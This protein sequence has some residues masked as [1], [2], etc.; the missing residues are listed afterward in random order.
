MNY[1][2]GMF[3][4]SFDPL[5][6][7]HIHDIIRAASMCETL[8]VMISWCEGRESTSKE[9]RYRWILD[10]CRHLPNVK[11]LLIEDTAV[12]KAS[13]NTD[14]YWEKGAAD[15]KN[16]IGKPID[17][18]FCGTDYFGTNRF[19]SL[20]EPES[21]V[22]YFD[23]NE[24]PICSTNIR[25]WAFDNWSYIPKICRPYY[26]K[27]VLVVGGEST[28][29]STLVINLAL[30]YNT[31]Y[32]DEVGRDISDMA[33]SEDL[34]IMDDFN[35]IL[36]RHKVNELNAIK[37]SNKLLFI[38]TDSITTQF[39]ANLLL[40]SDEENKICNQLADAI[41]NINNYDLV[42]FLEPTV[43]FI[44]DGTRNEI[45]ASDRKKYS[46]QIKSL[47][48]KNNIKY[49]CLSG[50]YLSRFNESK[51]LIERYL[52]FPVKQEDNHD[53]LIDKQEEIKTNGT[54][55]ETYDF[56]WAF[57]T[58]EMRQQIAAYVREHARNSWDKQNVNL[59]YGV[60]EKKNSLI[61]TQVNYLSDLIMRTDTGFNYHEF[62]YIINGELMTVSC[63]MRDQTMA[64]YS[65]NPKDPNYHLVKQAIY[66]YRES[67]KL[68]LKRQFELQNPKIKFYRYM[69]DLR[70]KLLY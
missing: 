20:Y 4:G 56:E 12:N 57:L 44:Q 40:Q 55:A 17:V 25:Q 41:T 54:T 33:G 62:A 22:V 63:D 37:E 34:M 35:N 21:K 31:N 43:A 9:I 2:I 39:Y 51:K 1:K 6:I 59:A 19:E 11:I 8:F 3:G 23:R 65:V 14:Y 49:Y 66:F 60:I 29:K 18:V 61:L 42:L 10:S 16:A 24:V 52:I 45:I 67:S 48:N 28:G 47:L 70:K 50:D 64:N 13:Y 27:K 15:I 26:V 69:D 30:A 32:V 68:D 38:D 46:D 58:E 7:G 36:L 53:K 5:H